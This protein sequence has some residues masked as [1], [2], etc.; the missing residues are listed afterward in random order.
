MA[1]LISL[2]S[3]LPCGEVETSLGKKKILLKIGNRCLRRKYKQRKQPKTTS[4]E[5]Y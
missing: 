4:H 3:L 5:N 1:I 2:P